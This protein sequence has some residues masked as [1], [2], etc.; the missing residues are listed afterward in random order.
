MPPQ[1]YAGSPPPSPPPK[2]KLS[3]GALG[4]II[5]AVVVLAGGG[6]WFATKGGDDDGGDDTGPTTEAS[7]TPETTSAPETT[8]VQTTVPLTL[9]PT[10]VPSTTETLP[11]DTTAPPVDGDVVDLGLGVSMP[12]PDGWELTGND[13][14]PTL[15][16]GVAQLSLQALARAP[17]EDPQSL[18]QEYIDTF[19]SDFD[20]I[21]YDPSV[22]YDRI[23]GALPVD[24]YGVHYEIYDAESDTGVGIIGTAYVYVRA[25]GLSVIY[26]I[27]S[28][29]FTDGPPTDEFNAFVDSIIDAPPL[30]DAGTLTERDTFRVA[31]IHESVTVFD[32]A[33]YTLAPGFTAGTQDDGDVVASTGD[34]DF[35]VQRYDNLP[36]DA[37]MAA[38]QAHNALVYP[39]AVE[40]APVEGE[41]PFEGITRADVTWATQAGAGNTLTG[42][43]S[44]FYDNNT[45]SAYAVFRAWLGLEPSSHQP[46]ANF[47][48]RSFTNSF[49][50]I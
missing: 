12:I 48:M 1:G 35:E 49:T 40:A 24:Q 42:V 11:P 28:R 38:A 10:I 8:V 37:A 33:A 34:E 30:G 6:I 21:S 13:D 29:E 32:L 5:A 46:E 39:G 36:A 47:M 18:M 19:D 14:V 31:S 43:Y 26:D 3:P 23:D 16:D 50:T 9:P 17:G 41:S 20:A 2:K 44:V 15:T 25:D 27:F 22:R 45:G 7:T 4:A